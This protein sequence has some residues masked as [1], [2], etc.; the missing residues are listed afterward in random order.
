MQGSAGFFMAVA[1]GLYIAIE[2]SQWYNLIR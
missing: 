2:Y 1:F